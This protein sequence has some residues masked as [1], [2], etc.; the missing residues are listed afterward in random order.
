MT[1][2][3]PG[4]P[5]RPLRI[6]L[7]GPIG[8]GKSTLARHLAR[9][10][11]VLIDADRLAHAVTEPGTPTLPAIRA[12]F[13][14]GVFGAD[15]SLDRAALG[16]V[17]FSEEAALRDLEA[18]VHPAVRE[19]VNAALE[20][21][22]RSGTPFVII[23]AIKLMESGLST[24]CDEVW[25]IACDRATQRARLAGRGHDAADAGRRIAAQG[26]LAERL[27]AVATRVLRTD[28]PLA[29]V[30]AAA[31]VAL[32]AALGSRPAGH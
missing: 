4:T 32:D 14:D 28:G 25:L 17:V 22:D 18:I 26:D 29:G 21:A 19:R 7:T 23:E 20:D 8:C 31:D 6:G 5:H 27:T 24:I 11:G 12:R 1:V 13:G 30:L 9:R 15:G 3:G 10:G 16:T 2:P